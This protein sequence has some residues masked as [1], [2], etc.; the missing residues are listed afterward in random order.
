[1]A[2]TKKNKVKAKQSAV[3]I[4][5]DYDEEKNSLLAYPVL[6]VDG[7][8][9]LAS[10]PISYQLPDNVGGFFKDLFKNPK[11]AFKN[12]TKAISKA[13][14][15]VYKGAK[16]VLRSKAVKSI[17]GLAKSPVGQAAISAFAGPAVAKGV[18]AG[19][20]V[21]QGDIQGAL[22]SVI[23]GGIPGGN[24]LSMINPQGAAAVPQRQGIL[25]ALPR[26]LGLMRNVKS[27]LPTKQSINQRY[28][29]V[30]QYKPT[31][32]V[33]LLQELIRRL[34]GHLAWIKVGF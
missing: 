12:A 19:I 8:P 6:M 5:Y 27:Q 11:K 9:V 18:S 10:P 30:T 13:A 28:L 25:P 32:D 14:K 7:R 2:N 1:M 34:Q 15:K 3:K 16:K 4:R 22:S 31:A 17:F 23:P 21:V 24:M 26:G 33:I 29:Q 20:G